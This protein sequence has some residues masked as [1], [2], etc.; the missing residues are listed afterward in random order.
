M[1]YRISK[2]SPLDRDADGSYKPDS[3][4]N[5]SDIGRFFSNQKLCA[6]E[7]LDVEENYWKTLKYF[8]EFYGIDQFEIHDIEIHS[9]PSSFFS[10]SEFFSCDVF[11][12]YLHEGTV[13]SLKIIEMI[14]RLC[15][16]EEIWCK[17]QNQRGD[18]IH[19]G[20]DYYMYFGSSQKDEINIDTTKLPHGIFVEIFDSPYLEDT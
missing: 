5:V 3:W 16:R 19:F 7:Y 17:L 11:S 20:Y 18:F 6:K 13:C 12:E 10:K 1:N 8:L 2:Y 14:V 4:T 15:L 9:M